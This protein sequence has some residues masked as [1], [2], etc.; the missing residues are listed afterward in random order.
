MGMGRAFQY[1]GAKCVLTS[2]WSVE[3]KA[4]VK[5]VESFFRYLKEGTSKLEAL[6]NSRNQ[7]RND[8]YDHPF[9]WAPF[10]LVGEVK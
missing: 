10:I 9:F 8:G 7:I 5:L 3:Q 4:S 2:L 6:K 1:A